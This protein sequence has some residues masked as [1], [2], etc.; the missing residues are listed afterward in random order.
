L[1]EKLRYC[2]LVLHLQ[3]ELFAFSTQTGQALS[4]TL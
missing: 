1:V 4:L 2:D 3:S